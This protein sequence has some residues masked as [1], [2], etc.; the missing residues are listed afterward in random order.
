MCYRVYL[1]PSEVTVDPDCTIF[2]LPLSGTNT[3][4]AS[5]VQAD[6][7]SRIPYSLPIYSVVSPVMNNPPSFPIKFVIY[8][9][10]SGTG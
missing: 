5:E 9:N 4:P 3:S 10:P 8:V 6:V 1:V 7:L 2:L